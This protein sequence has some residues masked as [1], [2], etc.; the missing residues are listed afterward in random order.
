[1]GDERPR[2]YGHQNYSCKQQRLFSI[3]VTPQ[4]FDED[5]PSS[6]IHMTPACFAATPFKYWRGTIRYRFQVVASAYHK[7]RLRFVYDPRGS[8]LNAEYNVAYTHVMDLAKERDFT[9]DIGWGQSKPYLETVQVGNTFRP[10]DILPISTTNNYNGVIAVYV[11]NDLTSP[12][13]TVNND[14]VI[15]VF[16]EC[17][18]DIEMFDPIANNIGQLSYFEPQ[19]GFLPQM[20]ESQPDADLTTDESAPMMMRPVDTMA[21]TLTE[22]M[23]PLVFHA[24]PVVSFRQCLKRYA[25]HTVYTDLDT[26]TFR[27]VTI[28]NRDTPFYRG[29]D[30]T[31]IHNTDIG[32]PYNFCENTLWNYLT[33]AY[34]CVR[35]GMRIKYFTRIA[36]DRKE[37]HLVTRVPGQAIPAVVSDPVSLNSQSGIAA[38]IVNLLINT[39]NGSAAQSL[40]HNNVIEAELPYY[41][42]YRFR[43]ARKIR[44]IEAFVP[45][46]EVERS[47][48][49]YQRTSANE[50]N[51][52]AAFYSVAEDFNLGFFLGVP[53]CFLYPDP[54][55]QVP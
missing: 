18:D 10:F 45:N 25:F 48:H 41:A 8:Q 43:P 46:I 1:V 2:K 3:A 24:D 17:C 12:N 5:G 13:S 37:L 54:P 34:T 14:V 21:A 20:A 19:L 49:V 53:V 52:T 6:E 30:P 50:E 4:T 36:S 42:N 29:Y 7:G 38:N 33:P 40:F 28:R 15:N 26:S 47:C 11:V 16:T 31:G 9:L 23:T 51:Y 44:T 35:G 39:W 32:T 27:F 22:N 55:P